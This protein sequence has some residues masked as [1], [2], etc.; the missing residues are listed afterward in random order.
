MKMASLRG[1]LQLLACPSAVQSVRKSRH[2]RRLWL[3]QP[4]HSHYVHPRLSLRR[5][6]PT[7]H[8]PASLPESRVAVPPAS[9]T[10]P[11]LI[12]SDRSPPAR[13]PSSLRISC[14]GGAEGRGTVR[15]PLTQAPDGGKPPASSWAASAHTKICCAWP[16]PIIQCVALFCTKSMTAASTSSSVAPVAE[17]ASCA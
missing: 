17:R 6:G 13:T 14:G 11:V 5:P 2:Y 10:G 15:A 1:P 7:L 12:P 3:L 8:R 4:L 9:P 16:A